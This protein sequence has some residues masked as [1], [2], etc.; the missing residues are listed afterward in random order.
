MKAYWDLDSIISQLKNEVSPLCHGSTPYASHDKSALNIIS[1]FTTRQLTKYTASSAR[2]GIASF[3]VGINSFPYLADH[4][5]QGMVVLPGS[6]YIE[7]ALCVHRESLQ[8]TVGIVR[9]VAFLNPVILSD[10]DVMLTVGVQP[11][12]EH[13]VQYTFQEINGDS[14][15]PLASTPCA[16]VEITSDQS[17]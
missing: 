2:A 17:R 13:T 15:E 12:G 4:A 8:A 6:F 3:S 11:L 14:A 9:N 16:R 7:M 10:R 1:P 5:F